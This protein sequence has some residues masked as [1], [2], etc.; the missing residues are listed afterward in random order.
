MRKQRDS[1]ERPDRSGVKIDQVAIVLQGSVATFKT[2]Y[3]FKRTE[4]CGPD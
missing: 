3:V 2:L 4:L 1:A